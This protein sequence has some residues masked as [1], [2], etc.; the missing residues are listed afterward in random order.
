[1][2]D[3]EARIQ[4]F[5]DNLAWWGNDVNR[6]KAVDRYEEQGLMWWQVMG[7]PKEAALQQYGLEEY[8]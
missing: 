2:V 6:L 3:G 5:Q 4:E 7:K 8:Y 1:M